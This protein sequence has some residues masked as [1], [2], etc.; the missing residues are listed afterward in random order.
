MLSTEFKTMVATAAN[1][2]PQAKFDGTY[3]ATVTGC[4]SSTTASIAA[5]AA[6]TSSCSTSITMATTATSNVD[7]S[8]KGLLMT[9]A[10]VFGA[11]YMSI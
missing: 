5:G 7:E 1:G 8:R 9:I 3:S 11:L 4:Y 6:G 10:T 2:L